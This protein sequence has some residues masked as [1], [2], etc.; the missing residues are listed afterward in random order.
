MTPCSNPE[1]I[2][3]GEVLRR[4][5]HRPLVGGNDQQRRVDPPDPGQ[6]V[7]DEPLVTRNI[8]DADLAAP[9]IEANQAKPRSIVIARAFS[10]ASRSGSIPVNA[11][12]RVDLP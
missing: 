11:L 10:S 6:H 5:R 2:K 8:D 9:R 3:D 4:L 7:L 12:T 1:Q